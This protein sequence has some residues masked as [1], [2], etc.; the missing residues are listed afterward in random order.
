MSTVNA[1]IF[2][3]IHFPGFL[4]ILY[5]YSLVLTIVDVV[6]HKDVKYNYFKVVIMFVE[7]LIHGNHEKASIPC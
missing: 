5:T 4:T 1:F 2:K 3:G 7:K 6:Y